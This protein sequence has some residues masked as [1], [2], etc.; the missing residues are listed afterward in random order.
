MLKKL[1]S[2]VLLVVALAGGL[3]GPAFAQVYLFQVVKEDVD[4]YVDA[5]GWAALEYNITFKSSP[6]ADNMEYV[7]LGLPNGNFS[8]ASV[9]AEVDGKPITDIQQ[10]DPQYL[11]KSDSGV[12]LGL[13]ANAIRPGDTGTLHVYIARIDGIL[14]PGEDSSHPDYASLQFSPSYFGSDYVQGNTDLRVTIHMP[15]G[16]QTNEPVYYTP[17]SNWPG[18]DQPESGYDGNNRIYYS[19]QSAIA[20]ADTGYTFGAGFPAS[21]VPAGAIT[22][23]PAMQIDSGTVG[24][25][26]FGLF[27]VALFGVIIYASIWGARKRKL[28]YLPPKVAIEGHG[29]KRGLTAVEAAILM[30]QPMDKILTM[31]LFAV[32]KKGFAVV[33]KR[34]PLEITV[35]RPFAEDLQPYEVTFLE[36]FETK[37]AAARKKKLQDMMVDL[38]KTVTEKMRGFSMKET[39]AY[40]E[41]IIKAAWEQVEAANTPEVKSKKYEEVM[42]WTLMDK[43]YDDRTRDT[44]GTGPVYVPVWWPRYDPT[45]STTS[46]GGGHVSTSPRPSTTSTGSGGGSISLPSLPGSTFAASVVN[47]VQNFASGVLGDVTGFTSGV[48]NRTNPVPTTSYSGK[49]YSGGGGGGGGHSCVCACACACAGCACACAGGGR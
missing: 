27:F 36:A 38:V 45:Y 6:S 8:L 12:T 2:A 42:D 40:Y 24:C 30:Q 9:S 17:S 43:N 26:C 14:F 28:Q 13:G 4:L 7:D 41:S 11:Q 21:Y 18:D 37:E 22:K 47:G 23:K 39:V 32:V 44:F 25:I 46:T 16:V 15:P 1:L 34:E 10:A 49:G 35:N 33:T 29:I 3:A 5:E 19:W 20:R 31:V 48:T